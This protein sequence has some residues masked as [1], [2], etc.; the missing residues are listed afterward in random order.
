[1]MWRNAFLLGVVA[2]SVSGCVTAEEQRAADEA[3]CRS[4]GFT[5]RNDAFAECMQRIDLN[6]SANARAELYDYW[7]RPFYP[8]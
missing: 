6:R 2:I 5:K 3:K 7:G 1:M 8:Y 4:Y